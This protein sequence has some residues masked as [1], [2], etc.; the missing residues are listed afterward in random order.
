MEGWI[1]FGIAFATRRHWIFCIAGPHRAV[2]LFALEFPRHY[3]A[4]TWRVEYAFRR[5]LDRRKRPSAS[6]AA[7]VF[8][9]RTS[10]A[11][12][13]LMESAEMHA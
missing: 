6:A 13:T 11:K 4:A 12:A 2:S 1:E 9:N 7:S 3:R 8:R 5:T 10:A